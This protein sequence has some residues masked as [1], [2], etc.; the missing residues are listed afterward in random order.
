M[1][2]YRTVKFHNEINPEFYRELK[3][4]V[5]DYFKRTG[6]TRFGNG[7]MVFK[8][9]FMSSLF[10]VPYFLMIFHVVTNIWGI[11][12]MFVLMGFGM[13]GIG[14]SV[15]HDA[16]H[17]SCSKNKWVNKLLGSIIYL[18]G[19]NPLNW[20]IQH[21]VLHH[22]YTN[23]D[24]LDEDIDPGGVLRFSPH[25]K[26][27]PAFKYQH[28]Y[29]WFLYGLM[30]LSWSSI[31]DFKQLY[32]FKRQGLVG[33]KKYPFNKAMTNLII[34]KISYFIFSLVIPLIMLDI[35]WYMV[36]L[37]FFIMHFITGFIL[38]IIFQPA[39][40]VPSSEYP[41]PDAN[42]DVYSNWAIHQ[43]FTTANFA[44]K[45]KLFSWYVGGLNFQIEH[46][47]FPTICH[48]HYKKISEIVKKTTA[49]YG[50]PYHSVKT[51]GKAVWDHAI[52]LKRLGQEDF[53]AS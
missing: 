27:R 35:P 10:F 28:I 49:E 11:L 37:F 44:P 18:I 17:G 13:A 12:L 46:H 31:R 1:V 52:L 14:L 29:S 47:L 25:K 22:S 8:T 3:S 40:V 33:N 7:R 30:T 36:L 26:W 15:M 9:I 45:S 23:I 39:H 38:S 34:G 48:V 2:N 50:L 19:G 32:R 43:L 20:K 51:F 42:G 41:M 5:N 21:N 24:G 53:V 4:R 16:N 6:K